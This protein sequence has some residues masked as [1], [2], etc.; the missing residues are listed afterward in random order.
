MANRVRPFSSYCQIDWQTS[1]L[2]F[3]IFQSNFR[4][5]DHLHY[6]KKAQSS[7]HISQSQQKLTKS[8]HNLCVLWMLDRSF[9]II[10]HVKLHKESF[11]QKYLKLKYFPHNI[12][13]SSSVQHVW[14]KRLKTRQMTNYF[15][16]EWQQSAWME[17]VMI[18]TSSDCFYLF[19]FL[20]FYY[21]SQYP[22]NTARCILST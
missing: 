19:F 17:L 22:K 2:C 1:I 8:N 18:M 11:F 7:I 4:D 20:L 21:C 16:F 15:L 10:I 5:C 3:S 13:Y 14:W 6:N 12:T 9:I